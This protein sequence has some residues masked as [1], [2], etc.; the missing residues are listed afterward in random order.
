MSSS[1]WTMMHCELGD[2]HYPH[3]GHLC[4]RA[5]LDPN[6]ESAYFKGEEDQ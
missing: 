5:D 6:L 1:H 2:S 3:E 4:P